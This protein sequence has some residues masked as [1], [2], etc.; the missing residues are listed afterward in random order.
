MLFRST[1]TGAGANN[2]PTIVA[3]S[4]TILPVVIPPPTL[5]VSPVSLSFSAQAGGSNPAAQSLNITN[6]GG[7][8]MSWS[9]IPSPAWLNLTPVSSTAPSAPAVSVDITGLAAGNYS[10]AVLISASGA[11][12]SPLSIPVNLTLTAPPPPPPPPPTGQVSTVFII[13]MENHDWSEITA[14]VAPYIRGTLVPMGA[15]AEQYFNPPGNHP[16]EPNYIWLEAGSNLGLTSDNDAG[17]GNSVA[18][19]SHLVTYLSNAAISWKGYM[20]SMPAGTCPLASSGEYAAKHDPFVFFQD[21]T[22]NNDA[23]NANCIAHVVPYT[24]L[25]SDL[26]N[27]TVARYNFITPNLCND[28]HDCSVATGDTWLA[29]NLPAILNSNAYKN[30]GAIFI[31]WDESENSDGPIGMVVL[32][33]LAKVNYQN[34]IHYTHSSTVRTMQ[35][36]FG[37]GPY[38]NDAANATDLSDL[39]LSGAIPAGITPPSPP[40]PPPSPVLSVSPNSIS[41][42]GQAGGTNPAAQTVNVS[43]TGGGTLN[44]TAAATQS[45]LGLSPGSGAAPASFSAT[46]NLAGLA[47]GNYSDTITVTSAGVSG[48]PQLVSVSLVVS[49]APPPPPPPPPPG[50]TVGAPRIFFSDLTSGPNSGGQNNNGTILT[51]YGIRFGT[52]QGSS[53]V[54]V[55]GGTVAAYLAWSDSKVSFAIGSAA[56]SGNVLVTTSLGTSNAVPF[57]VR[58]GNIYFV[59]TNGADSNTGA[60]ASPWKTVLK[61]KSA[62][63]AGDITYAMDGVLQT[64]QDTFTASFSVTSQEG[65]QASPFALV[66]YPG[67]TVTIGATGTGLDAIRIPNVSVTADYWTIANLHLIADTSAID[68]GGGVNPSTG[69]RIVG[70]YISCPK[71]NGQTGCVST[72]RHSNLYFLGNEVTNT[73]VPGASKQYHAVYF[74]TDTNHV[75]CAWNNIHDNNTCRAIQFHSSPLCNPSCGASDTTGFDQ[76]DLHVHD[77]VIHGDACDGINF[78]T[79][80]PS[81]GTVEAYNNVIYHVGVGP[82]PPDGDAN[83]AGIYSPG[84]TNSGA[85][86]KGA[87]LVYNNTIYDAGSHAASWGGNGALGAFDSGA[88]LY[89]LAQNNLIYQLG[90]EPYIE[91]GGKVQGDHNLFFGNGAAPAGFTASLN[92]DPM[93]VNLSA[94]NFQLSAGSPAIDAGITTG[95]ATDLL[96][97]PRPQGNAF[98]LGA[99]EFVF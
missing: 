79:V 1:F 66:G 49:A 68:L 51:I 70:N 81:K 39:F 35:N 58:P 83:Y 63:L 46:A 80:D 29:S 64:A 38:L 78:A 12:G 71:G 92:S 87:I 97:V 99:Y 33:P 3:V 9:A 41:F 52:T 45:W 5:T 34:S 42:S 48:S 75:W 21:V 67:A 65:T 24:Q 88:G 82:A 56:A 40:P 57:T 62:M 15:H 16:S 11:Q 59:A 37:V 18:T 26:Q 73:G 31:T 96:G 25:A 74:T 91:W 20:E 19:T 28:M 6:T 17:P 55:G 54:T 4:L 90:S 43:N 8:A 61:A 77:N 14:S 50:N 47:A 23:N 22:G 98:D 13:L 95:A 94:F 44:W 53:L 72:S 30:N 69:W 76:Y 60:F 32:S 89:I 36:I 86:G 10:G 93:F 2:S 27:G 85:P 7:G 84:Y